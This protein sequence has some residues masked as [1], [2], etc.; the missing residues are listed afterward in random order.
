MFYSTDDVQGEQGRVRF[1]VLTP[2]DIQHRP[3]TDSVGRQLFAV[4]QSLVL[5]EI[6]P[7]MS[8]VSR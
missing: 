2:R 5:G 3:R 1:G 4:D 7:R 8:P 6:T